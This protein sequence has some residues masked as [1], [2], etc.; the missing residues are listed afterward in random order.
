LEGRIPKLFYSS[1]VE[2]IRR[3]RLRNHAGHWCNGLILQLL[4]ITR[5]GSGPSAMGRCI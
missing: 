5:K 4:Q 1:R 3:L 2:D